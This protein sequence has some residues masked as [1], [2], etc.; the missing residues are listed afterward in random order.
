MA[1]PVPDHDPFN[2]PSSRI[3][4]I[5]DRILETLYDF[6]TEYITTDDLYANVFH[7]SQGVH[8]RMLFNYAIQEL[9]ST[10]YVSNGAYISI[11]YLGRQ[12]Y[13]SSA[14]PYRRRPCKY[15]QFK[16]RIDT[17]WN[18]IKVIAGVLNALAIIFFAWYSITIQKEFNTKQLEIQQKEIEA[19]KIEQEKTNTNVKNNLDILNEQAAGIKDIKNET[20]AANQPMIKPYITFEYHSDHKMY[21]FECQLY[22]VGNRTAISIDVDIAITNLSDTPIHIKEHILGI[23]NKQQEY[24]SKP[25]YTGGTLKNKPIYILVKIKFEDEGTGEKL[26]RI[27]RLKGKI[28]DGYFKMVSEQFVKETI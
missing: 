10:E 8:Q 21:L 27:Y 23:I 28:E 19:N 7:N 5:K 16:Q 6:A 17:W 22:N 1:I 15:E 18:A 25:L 24:I 12:F 11:T 2:P 3:I 20:K 9:D 14:W 4:D 26:S 13:E